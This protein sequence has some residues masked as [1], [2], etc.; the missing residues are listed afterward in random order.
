MMLFLELLQ[1]TLVL[2]VQLLLLGFKAQNSALKKVMPSVRARGRTGMSQREV[3]KGCGGLP[4]G[5]IQDLLRFK[6]W[7]VARVK[8]DMAARRAR[9]VSS[10]QAPRRPTQSSAYCT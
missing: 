2:L 6:H 9:T 10:M 8:V 3:G 5:R 4:R 7:H 1:V